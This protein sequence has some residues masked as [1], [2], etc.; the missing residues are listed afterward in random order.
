MKSWLTQTEVQIAVADKLR[1]RLRERVRLNPTR[2]FKVR[3]LAMALLSF[4]F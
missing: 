1:G 4:L 3:D 2:G